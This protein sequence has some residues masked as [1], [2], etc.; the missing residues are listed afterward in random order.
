MSAATVGEAFQAAISA[1]DAAGIETARLDAEVLLEHA[2]GIGRTRFAAEPKLPMPEG[3]SRE[4]AEFVRRRIAHE[5]V[6]YITGHKG[7]RHILLECDPR[8]LIPRPETELLVEVAVERAPRR[9][10]DL[11]TGTGAVALAIADEVA[12]CEVVATDTSAEAL[13]L[14]RHNAHRLGLGDR[15]ELMEGSVPDGAFD[16]V[17]A[18]LPYVTE[19]EWTALAPEITLYEPRSAL[20]GGDDGLGVIDAA[21]AEVGPPE[22]GA[23]CETPAVA[24]EIGE[25]QTEEAQKRVRDRGYGSTS[26]RPDLAGIERVVIGE[27][28]E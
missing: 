21:L 9:V 28:A 13:A 12:D 3:S 26:V 23:R 7:F 15:I 11:G 27:V 20:V 17:V 14:A 19:S 2:T 5:P 18:N 8:A 10:A 4:F 1:I 25:G 6:A 22:S 24:L 16:L